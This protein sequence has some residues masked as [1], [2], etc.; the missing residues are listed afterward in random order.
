MAKYQ[1][2]IDCAFMPVTLLGDS[3]VRQHYKVSLILTL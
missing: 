2:P 1:L 3:S